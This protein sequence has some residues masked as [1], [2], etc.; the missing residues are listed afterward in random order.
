MTKAEKEHL[1]KVASLGCI[2]C[3]NIAEIHHVRTGMGLGQRNTNFNVIPL[4]HVHHRT[5]GH[6]VAFHAGKKTWQEIFGTEKDLL[7]KT[8][9]QI[10]NNV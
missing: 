8:I 10:N 6:G 2:I 5:G 7:E 4:C 1:N 3:G 9:N